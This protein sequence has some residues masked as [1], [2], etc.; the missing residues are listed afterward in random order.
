MARKP[1]IF[2]IFQGEGSEPLLSP[3]GSAQEDGGCFLVCSCRYAKFNNLVFH[4]LVP[5]IFHTWIT[6]IKLFTKFEPWDCH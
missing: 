6:F 1:Y 5:S 4:Y 3:S 2:V